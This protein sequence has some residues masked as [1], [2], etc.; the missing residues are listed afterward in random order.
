[1][2]AR[3]TIAVLILEGPLKVNRKLTGAWRMELKVHMVFPSSRIDSLRFRRRCVCVCDMEEFTIS[4]PKLPLSF[5]H[6]SES[7]VYNHVHELAGA[8]PSSKW[9]SHQSSL[10]GVRLALCLVQRRFPSVGWSLPL[11][12]AARR[13]W[14]VRGRRASAKFWA[15]HGPGAHPA[16]PTLWASTLRALPLF[17]GSFQ[18]P[19][20]L[21]PL[22]APHLWAPTP[23]ATVFC[24]SP[25]GPV[26][27]RPGQMPRQTFS[28]IVLLCEEG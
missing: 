5:S 19:P 16:G 26:A 22:W 21:P 4:Q 2:C 17:L 15:P 12:R 6:I 27:K 8:L 14:T 9:S 11:A 7:L 18:P 1:M 28:N 25:G 24:S 20:M 10:S 3:K 23:T 13:A